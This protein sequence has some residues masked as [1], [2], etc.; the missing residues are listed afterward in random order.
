MRDLLKKHAGLPV[1]P[2][3]FLLLV[4]V[5]LLVPHQASATCYRHHARKCPGSEDGYHYFYVEGNDDDW[6]MQS[7][8]SKTLTCITCGA[9]MIVKPNDVRYGFHCIRSWTVLEEP[10]ATNPRGL[11]KGQCAGCGTWF[12]EPIINEG[13][14]WLIDH[15]TW[16][17]YTDVTFHMVC[18]DPDCTETAVFEATEYTDDR[19]A[20]CTKE[21]NRTHTASVLVNTVLYS[22]SAVEIIPPHDPPVH[23]P[24]PDE[25]KEP[26]VNEYGHIAGWTCSRCGMH[27]TSEDGTDEIPDEEWI[28]LKKPLQ[29]G[30]NV[31]RLE[32]ENKTVS[33]AFTLSE[34]GRYRFRCN[35]S[36]IQPEIMICD[37]D[38][39]EIWP[40]ESISDSHFFIDL[41]AGETYCLHISSLEGTG[42]I[43]VHIGLP[44]SYPL[45]LETDEYTSIE[46]I[47]VNGENVNVSSSL[48]VTDDQTV[49]LLLVYREGYMEDH[50]SVSAYGD[51]KIPYTTDWNAYKG[52][53]QVLR[54]RMPD[55]ETVAAVSARP[56]SFGQADFV[57]P[58]DTLTVGE[59][60]FEGDEKITV[61]VIPEGCENIG[62]WSF[63]NCTNLTYIRIPGECFVED[64]AF[65]GCRWV[66]IVSSENSPAWQYC[67]DHEENCLFIKE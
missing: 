9:N 7:S 44:A 42:D 30:D 12:E 61:A 13:H 26:I 29:A 58:A 60:A 67:Q 53:K 28:L 54:F 63:R 17:S 66:F 45:T 48:E 25:R 16:N 3:F 10:S 21:K 34:S 32:E 47:L 41:E 50:S 27:F 56:L 22:D 57:L 23:N 43:T 38:D 2:V 5:I 8:Q 59:S 37:D 14:A 1:I 18:C 40:D 6:Y 24:V 62:K 65:D 55:S 19:K 4:L 20:D 52:L 35:G 31:I 11:K 49:E 15:V 36:G 51:D 33:I 64:D 46:G 39:E